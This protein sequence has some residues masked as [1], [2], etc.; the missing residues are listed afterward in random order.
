MSFPLRVA[1]I[2]GR[3][4]GHPIHVKYAKSLKA[5]IYNVDY[6]LRY[7]DISDSSA[8][9]RYF[10]WLICALLFPKKRMYD[11]FFSEEAYFMVGLLRKFRLISKKQKLIAL[12]ASHTLYFLDTGKYSKSTVKACKLLFN[13]YDAFICIGDLQFDLLKKII[14]EDSQVKVFKIFNGIPAKKIEI[15]NKIRCD[16]NGFNILFIGGVENKNRI[17]YKGL[18]LMLETYGKL[19]QDIPNLTFTIVGKYCPDEIPRI[20]SN[21]G[22]EM[23]PGLNFVGET[24][25]ITPFLEK[26]S[27][28]L[29]CSRGDAFPT[30][31]LEAMAA[32]I[33]PIV[34]DWTGTMGIVKSLDSNLIASLDPKDIF[35]K[36]L[37][38]FNLPSDRKKLLSEEAK[39]IIKNEYSEDKAIT[40]FQRVILKAYQES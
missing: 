24:N 26:A 36:V 29:H 19:R 33:I 23:D 11:I 25:D 21:L 15:F 13:T 6:K 22:L 37:Y 5:D 8:F 10:S 20:L 31:T 3:P 9:R 27:L 18:D 40:N 1:F 39:K 14:G 16:V 7:H 12:M 28:Y 30:S 38:Y 32:G 35:N 17:W 2:E 34:S 4:H